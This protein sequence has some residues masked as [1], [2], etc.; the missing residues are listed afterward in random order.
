MRV[1]ALAS[2]RLVLRR[3]AEH[4]GL[5]PEALFN[6]AGLDPEKIKDPNARYSEVDS[7]RLLTPIA[8]TS[9]SPFCGLN[10]GVFWHPSA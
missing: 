1:T 5:N 4:Y 6:A 7:T 10:V 2:S 3:A 9:G 8:E